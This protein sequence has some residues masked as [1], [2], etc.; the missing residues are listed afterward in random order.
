MLPVTDATAGRMHAKRGRPQSA[1]RV[2]TRIAPA[3]NCGWPQVSALARPLAAQVCEHREHAAVRLGVHVETELEE[4]LL[5]VRFDG[6]LGD[7][8]AACDRAVGEAFRDQ[9][10]HL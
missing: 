10:E 6:P 3:A 7:E 9:A 1:L 5:D 8:E 2:G 4:D